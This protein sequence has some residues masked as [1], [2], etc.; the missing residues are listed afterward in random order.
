MMTHTIP[1][2]DKS[3]QIFFLFL[4]S[5]FF[6]PSPLISTDPLSPSPHQAHSITGVTQEDCLVTHILQPDA[7]SHK[8]NGV[9]VSICVKVF[10]S[11]A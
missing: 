6:Q 1:D 7:E 9:C 3:F 5:T 4:F 10:Y 11:K 8:S 2:F